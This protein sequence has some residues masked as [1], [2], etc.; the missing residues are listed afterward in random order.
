[1]CYRKQPTKSGINPET[2]SD[3]NDLEDVSSGS[4]SDDV[5]SHVPAC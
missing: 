5:S 3:V 1:M 2:N 4:K